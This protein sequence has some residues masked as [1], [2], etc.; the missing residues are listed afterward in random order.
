MLI[1]GQNKRA[2][3]WILIS[4]RVTRSQYAT[5]PYT[6]GL[7]YFS[8]D[9]QD[10][11]Q[12]WRNQ[13]I[14]SMKKYIEQ[15]PDLQRNLRN[16]RQY[17]LSIDDVVTAFP[18]FNRFILTYEQALQSIARHELTRLKDRWEVT[19]F[20]AEMADLQSALEY[21]FRIFSIKWL[22]FEMREWELASAL[23]HVTSS[24]PNKTAIVKEGVLKRFFVAFL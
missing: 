19:G 1:S 4:N 17:E 22:L 24:T 16:Y 7:P 13:I 2:S 5:D 14:P 9:L 20:E 23:V 15:H 18:E 8:A 11:L 10:Q 6:G 21:G 3:E 12:T